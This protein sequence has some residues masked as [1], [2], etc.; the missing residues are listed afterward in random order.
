M[1]TTSNFIFIYTLVLPCS[2][3]D[4]L[5]RR[6]AAW[7]HRRRRRPWNGHNLRCARAI[8]WAAPASQIRIN[9]KRSDG[10]NFSKHPITDNMRCEGKKIKEKKNPPHIYIRVYLGLRRPPRQHMRKPDVV[11]VCL[12]RVPV[13]A[14]ALRHALIIS[15][16]RV[17]QPAQR[18]AQARNA[19]AAPL[20][21]TASA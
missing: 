15:A 10:F 11:H 14:Q 13:T 2:A 7:V 17:G 4:D 9:K 12:H 21:L 20:V 18:P 8:R 16:P 6:L 19:T 1:I 3:Q 5:C